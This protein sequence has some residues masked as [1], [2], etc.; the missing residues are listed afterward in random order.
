VKCLIEEF[1]LLCNCVVL[2]LFVII[3]CWGGA[4]TRL[5]RRQQVLWV[6]ATA[7]EWWSCDGWAAE[8]QREPRDDAAKGKRARGSEGN[9]QRGSEEDRTPTGNR[10]Q[11]SAKLSTVS[12]LDE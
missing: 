6:Q 9:G 1:L 11:P 3:V 12:V 5:G 10:E 2:R 4:V 8:T 7:D